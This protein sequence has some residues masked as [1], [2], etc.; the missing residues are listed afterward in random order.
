MSCKEQILR[1]NN[2]NIMMYSA[3]TVA[4]NEPI[5]NEVMNRSMI[6]LDYN[7]I[8]LDEIHKIVFS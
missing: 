1:E 8:M 2:N 3:V 6:E 7:N 4:Q 5:I